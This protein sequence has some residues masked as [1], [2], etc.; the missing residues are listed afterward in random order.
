VPSEPPNAAGV[1][2]PLAAIVSVAALSL[3]LALF[4]TSRVPLIDRDEGRYAEVAREMVASGDWLVPRLFGVPYLEKPPLFHW[5]TAA[6][7]GSVGMNELG[8]RLVSGVAAAVGVLFTGL[9]AH[10]VFGAGAGVA[11]AIVLATSGLYFVLARVAVT[12]ML[13]SVLVA[14]ALM[15]YFVA[16]SERRSFLP[17]WLLAAAATLTKGPVAALLC[18]LPVL[19]HLAVLGDARTLRSGRFWLG[20]LLYLALVGSWFGS[21]EVRYPGFLR[22]YVYKEHVLRAAGDEHRE[23]FYWYVPWLIVGFLPWTPLWVAALP[24]IW[25][26]TEETSISGSAARFA[27]IWVA[28]ILVFF[29]IPRGKLVPYILPVFPALAILLGDALDRWIGM[30]VAARG[31]NRAITLVGVVLLAGAGALPVAAFLAPVAIPGALVL[32][33]CAL[34]A[35]AAVALLVV[36][37][38]RGWLPVLALAGAVAAAE[39]MAAMIASSVARPLTAQAVIDV[40]RRRLGP[41]DVLACYSGYFPSVPFYLQRIPYFVAGNRELDFGVSLEGGGPWVV[42]NLN[43]LRARSEG[44]RIFFVLRTRQSDFETLEGLPGTVEVLHRGRTASLIEYRP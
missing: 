5:L 16:E 42:G 7:C 14:G 20:L 44:R 19:G 40:L 12:D 9:F 1:R 38:R 34:A 35:C 2:R 28:I 33:A 4:Y 23:A 13:F 18:G 15:A 21:V 32:A 36:R 27:V 6:S 39:C 25:R 41:G 17:F 11:A 10:R 26:R 3:V 30:A 37:N 8:A 24:T 22:F 29:S 31:I 43:Q